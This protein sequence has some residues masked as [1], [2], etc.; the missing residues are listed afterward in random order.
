MNRWVG[1]LMGGQLVRQMAKKKMMMMIMII[2]TPIV[3]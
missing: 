2:K 1:Q 3:Y